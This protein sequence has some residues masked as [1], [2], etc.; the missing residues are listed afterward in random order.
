[1]YELRLYV[2]GPG[3]AAEQRARLFEPFYT[4]KVRGTGLGLAF[5]KRIVDAHGGTIEPADDPGP[6]AA[7]VITLPRRREL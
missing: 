1:V 7:I 6:G 2:P 3:F 4:T 5:C